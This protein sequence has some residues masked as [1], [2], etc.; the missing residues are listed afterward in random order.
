M[1]LKH[2]PLFCAVILTGIAAGLG[3]AALTWLIH[4]I[5]YLA[6]GH[7]EAQ[8][9]IVTEGTTPQQRIIAMLA[10]GVLVGAGWALLQ[11]KG[12]PLAAI[13]AMVAG[14]GNGR[15]P[16]LPESIAHA[17]LQIAAVGCGAPVGREVAP[18]ELGALFA[19]RIAERAGLDG[20]T[21]RVLVACGAAAGLAAVYHV[22]FAGALFALEILL[23]VFSAY[24]AAI[25]L[26]VSAVAVWVARIAVS[27]ETFYEVGQMGG[28]STEIVL[29][30]V[31]GAAVAAPAEWFRR[32]VK[33][34]EQRRCSGK[35]LLWTLPAAFLLTAVIAVWLP[36]IL[37]NGR[38]AAQTAYWGTGL[39]IAAALLIA[40]TGVVLLCLR[41][42]AYGGT[43]TPGL[44]I[45]ALAGLCLGLLGQ[46]VWPTLDPTAAAL[47]GSA[48]FLA[49]SM[50]A[51]LTAFA[52]VVGF[53]GQNFDAYLPLSFAVAAAMGVARWMMPSETVR[54]S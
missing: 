27:S 39:G 35:R 48:A 38:S 25:A 19:T 33:R 50:N 34:A 20:E 29:A 17:V 42:G 22:P 23:G 36:Q 28:G 24:Y 51:P 30:I 40:K 8:L 44:A 10:G 52:L 6:F 54:Q 43:L 5:E 1:T 12:R 26:A 13:G 47:A 31:I 9:R 14:S 18:R 15:R 49:V 41:S 11:N 46:M 4:G 2:L 53:T 37:G 21:R 45:G 32:S 7:S 16:P 3:A